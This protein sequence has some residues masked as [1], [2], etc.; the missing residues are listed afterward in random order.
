ML[1]TIKYIISFG[2][3]VPRFVVYVQHLVLHALHALLNTHPRLT[4]PP[5]PTPL[6]PS[7]CFSRSTVSHGLSSPPISPVHFSF[8][9]P[10]VLH[11]IPYVPQESETI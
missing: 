7:V 6:K 2:R 10:D 4:H 9:S 3:S 11:V 5:P 1:V 8:P